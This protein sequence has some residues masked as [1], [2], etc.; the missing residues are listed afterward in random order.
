[1]V[2]RVLVVDDHDEVRSAIGRMLAAD[3]FDIVGEASDGAEALVLAR[4]DRPDLVVLD[5]RLPGPDGFEVAR[6]LARLSPAPAVV[7]I[8]SHEAR[9]YDEQVLRSPALAFITKSDLSGATLRQAL[10]HVVP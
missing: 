4:A 1:M 6:E 5:I 2:L 10:D 9:V 8:S 7:L 3:G